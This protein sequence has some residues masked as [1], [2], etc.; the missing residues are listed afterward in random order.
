MNKNVSTGEVLTTAF[1][2]FWKFKVLWIFG[3]CVSFGASVLQ[4]LN[5][6]FNNILVNMISQNTAQ[7]GNPYPG[8]QPEN[9]QTFFSK[10]SGWIA[11]A[12]IL[13]LVFWLVSFY[14]GLM[15]RIALLKGASQADEGAAT[16]K[17]GELWAQSKP[18]FWRIFWLDSVVLLPL[19]VF[20]IFLVI[21]LFVFGAVSAALP[22]SSAAATAALFGL[23]GFI[24]CGYCPL[25]IGSMLLGLI[26]GQAYMA[27][28]LED[29]GLWASFKR[30]W[31]VFKS[32]WLNL[33]LLTIILGIGGGLLGAVVA[34]PITILNQAAIFGALA[35]NSPA[36]HLVL[37]AGI[38]VFSLPVLLVMYSLVSVF[39][40]TVWTLT[41]RRLTAKAGQPM[42]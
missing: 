28:V 37:S 11:A 36:T 29:L 40:Q 3:A 4:S 6:G 25:V 17:F 27:I 12:V 8:P 15:G 35:G 30:G 5:Y 24:L 7:P 38:F 33:I 42:I 26:I 31:Q 19:C 22:G 14:L 2:I 10:Y 39:G 32:G 20:L 18:F 21:G 9:I 23:V 16:L 1:K 34:I 13:L 41:Y